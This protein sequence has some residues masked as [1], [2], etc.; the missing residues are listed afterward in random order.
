[1][2]IALDAMGGDHA[3][4]ETV[5]GAVMAVR[6]AEVLGLANQNLEVVL[7]GR[8]EDIE[9]ELAQAGDYPKKSISVVDAREIVGM[10]ESPAS[11]C[12]QKRDSS[13]VRC[14]GLVK[15]GE[16]QATVSA[17]NSGAAMAAALMMCGRI[18]GV[19]RPAITTMVPSMSGVSIL[20]DAGANVDSQAKHLLQFALM[21]DA[22]A[23]AL[24]FKEPRVG[25]LSIGEE[26][27]KGNELVFATQILLKKVPFNYIGNV[28]GRDIINGNC[29]V[30][31]CDG[32]VGNIALKAIESTGE[33]VMTGLKNELK[34]NLISLLGGLIAQKAFRAF[35][36]KVDWKEFGAAPLLGIDGL[37]LIAHGKSDAFTIKN[38]IRAAV[39]C[40]T[41]DMNGYLKE[42]I[43]LH[44][45]VVD[46][47]ESK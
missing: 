40:V 42:Q 27:T 7:V 35:K 18:D 22:F 15:T 45:Q 32:F 21:G 4:K 13:V 46:K 25:L 26:E 44:G 11:A 19:L 31:V 28:E 8:K 16:V 9:R 34:S 29:D 24:G 10:G 47:P 23:R 14:A 38:G 2:K 20:V 1:M 33:L 36:K 43:N 39:R 41:K 3:P 6:D 30:T 37:C 12:R 17:G 5:L